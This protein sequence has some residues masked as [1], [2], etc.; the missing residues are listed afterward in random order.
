V[1]APVIG[2]DLGV[3]R[4]VVTR[5]GDDGPGEPLVEPT[6]RSDIDAL[7]DQ[8]QTLVGRAAPDEPRA[9]ALG[10]PRI[11]DFAVG[12]V[13]AT[14]RRPTPSG[15]GAV[16][17]PLAGVPLR[18]LLEERFGL[19]VVVDNITNFAAFAEAHN[20]SL[21]RE[22]QHLVMLAVGAGVSGGLILG[23]EIYR[24][25]SGGA[26]ELGQ[27]IVG[28]DLAGAVPAPMRF[29]QPGSVEFVASGHALDGLAGQ[30]RNVHPSSALAALREQGKPVLGTDV[31]KAAQAGDQSAARMIEIWGQRIGIAVANVINTFDPE[32][33]VIGGYAAHAGELLLEA[34]RRIAAGYVVPGLGSR[35]VT[36]LPRHGDRAG[37]LGAALYARSG[38]APVD[39]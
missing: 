37:V 39:E 4:V 2:I 3:T 1:S 13:V 22:T 12:R 31:I 17:L 32:E 29:P 5:L 23:G 19:P 26:G 35:T 8:L 27:T 6:E 16:D 7:V 15:N 30:A 34:A 25:A 14:A 24:G 21:A 20:E 33:V 18:E 38:V 11:V 9:V 10:V 28:L 36:R